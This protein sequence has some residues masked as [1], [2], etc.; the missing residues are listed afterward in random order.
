MTP[1]EPSLTRPPWASTLEA[2]S[3]ML[4][5]ISLS[6]A[7]SVLPIP[8]FAF[9][10]W[11]GTR[12]SPAVARS[13]V[14]ATGPAPAT[15]T[16]TLSR[17]FSQTAAPTASASPSI[18]STTGSVS[19]TDSAAVT[20]GTDAENAFPGADRGGTASQWGV[21]VGA[22]AGGTLLLVFVVCLI[23]Y[24]RRRHRFDTKREQEEGAGPE[25]GEGVS[26]ARLTDGKDAANPYKTG[27]QIHPIPSRPRTFFGLGTSRSGKHP[28]EEASTSRVST[29]T[30]TI[31]QHPRKAPKP[32]SLSSKKLSK[33]KKTASRYTT[34]TQRLRE[35][36]VSVSSASTGFSTMSARS[37]QSPRSGHGQGQSALRG[38]DRRMTFGAQSTLLSPAPPTAISSSAR[39]GPSTTEI[40][41]SLHVHYADT[42][43]I[44]HPSPASTTIR[45]RKEST[46]S[47]LRKP[48]PIR[49]SYDDFQSDLSSI[50][51]GSP[52]SAAENENRPTLGTLP[53]FSTSVKEIKDHRTRLAERIAADRSSGVDIAID[54]HPVSGVPVSMS[55]CDSRQTA[56][57]KSKTGKK[58]KS[59]NK[60]KIKDKPNSKAAIAHANANAIAVSQSGRPTIPSEIP[61]S[62]VATR[63]RAS[64]LYASYYA[65][66][67]PVLP[68]MVQQPLPRPPSSVMSASGATTRGRPTID[69]SV[70]PPLSAT[71]TPRVSGLSSTA[72]TYI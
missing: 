2:L 65:P 15:G 51:S 49:S 4:N 66:V 18:R 38:M 26:G 6:F 27:H 31:F 59:K 64:T 42:S 9:H 19:A 48:V 39:E 21:I 67:P 45:I 23:I 41:P 22:V 14:S 46:R 53:S 60:N 58:N 54:A 13:I 62:F 35:K 44:S 10:M 57:H 55:D 71:A 24:W 37:L 1:R 69:F 40:V 25:N 70:A 36:P 33:S 7:Q 28:V 50:R 20:S 43:S 3:Q 17:S 8:T 30:N 29:W 12:W 61:R 68:D 5:L 11:Q 72:R 52:A 47:S 56:P 34:T 32:A 63:A 16:T